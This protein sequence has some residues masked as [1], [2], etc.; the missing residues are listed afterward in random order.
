MATTVKSSHQPSQQPSHSSLVRERVTQLERPGY[1][2]QGS[3]S[4]VPKPKG[5][6]MPSSLDAD[7]PLDHSGGYSDTSI[8]AATRHLRSG[9]PLPPSRCERER[10]RKD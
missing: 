1:P 8:A 5:R 4:V 10:G 3:S 6:G 7:D 9:S 2:P